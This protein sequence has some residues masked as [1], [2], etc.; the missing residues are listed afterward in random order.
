M[1]KFKKSRRTGRGFNY[2][3]KKVET[4]DVRIDKKLIFTKGKSSVSTA[5]HVNQICA[6]T[7][8]ELFGLITGRRLA[9]LSDA[10][11]TLSQVQTKAG[12]LEMT[13]S[14]SRTLTTRTAV[15]IISDLGFNDNFTFFDF[16]I[17]N[18]S[19]GDIIRLAGGTDVTI[20]GSI[21]T[22]AGTSSRYSYVRTSSTEI[23]VIRLA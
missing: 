21:D 5:S 9:T 19:A 16:S 7:N 15:E 23:S 11:A 13:P 17:I 1:T 4:S 22:A 20:K 18:L 12:V 3:G 14:T 10:S 8:G 6:N 2:I